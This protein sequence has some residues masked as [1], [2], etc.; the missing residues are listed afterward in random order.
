MRHKDVGVWG[1]HFGPHCCALD[2]FIVFVHE[3]K[4]V[5]FEYE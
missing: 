2:L 3:I 5:V 4:L 1:C